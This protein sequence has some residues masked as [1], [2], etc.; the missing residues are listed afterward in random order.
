M[1]DIDVSGQV[2][3]KGSSLQDTAIDDFTCI[4]GSAYHT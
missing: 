2:C 4:D 3:S 1:R